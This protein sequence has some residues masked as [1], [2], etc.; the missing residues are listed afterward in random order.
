[1][2]YS[3]GYC[4][5][6]TID[7]AH[8]LHGPSSLHKEDDTHQREVEVAEDR[9]N[10]NTYETTISLVYVLDNTF[11]PFFFFP[12]FTVVVVSSPSSP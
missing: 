5:Y 1:M 9:D 8:G 2:M 11:R 10:C 3:T 6:G 12:T 7:A 4:D